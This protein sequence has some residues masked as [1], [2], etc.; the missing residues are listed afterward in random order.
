MRHLNAGRSLGVSRSHRR[1]MLRNLVTSLFEHQQIRTTMARAKELKRVADKMVTL[2]KKGDLSARREALAFVKSKE[3]MANLFGE[4]AQRYANRKGG[5]TRVLPM[6]S[7][8][9]DNAAMGLIMMVDGPNDPFSTGKTKA[10]PAAKAKKKEVIEEVAEEVKAE[11]KKKT[12]KAK[13]ETAQSQ[14]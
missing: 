10:K 4:F 13:A 1:A 7:R 8:Y 2:G 12:T 9:G 5:Y 3:A 14:G 11:T 6:E